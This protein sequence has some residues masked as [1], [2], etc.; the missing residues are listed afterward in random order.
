MRREHSTS[1]TKQSKV[2]SKS[3]CTKKN[4]PGTNECSECGTTMLCSNC[5]EHN[6]LLYECPTHSQNATWQKFKAQQAHQRY[7]DEVMGRIENPHTD[8]IP[9]QCEE[10]GK[11]DHKKPDCPKYI[12]RRKRE[13]EVQRTEQ[14][15]RKRNLEFFNKTFPD[16]HKEISNASRIVDFIK[17]FHTYGTIL[18]LESPTKNIDIHVGHNHCVRSKYWDVLTTDQ[19]VEFLANNGNFISISH[20]KKGR[21]NPEDLVLDLCKIGIISYDCDSKERYH[22]YRYNRVLYMTGVSWL[23][24][25]PKYTVMNIPELCQ[26]YDKHIGNEWGHKAAEDIKTE[27]RRVEIIYI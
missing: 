16:Q 6:H 4:H 2:I 20:M 18:C 14:A 25:E 26:L 3:T 23:R 11:S 15:A 1:S 9:L 8:P 27:T 12:A 13:A 22:N 24:E 17:S 7:L 10:C 21:R 5:G 19:F